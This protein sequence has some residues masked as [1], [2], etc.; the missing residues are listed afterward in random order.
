MGN[1]KTAVILAVCLCLF[2]GVIAWAE[3]DEKNKKESSGDILLAYIQ[4]S[5]GEG[6]SS[7]AVGGRL[8]L[9]VDNNVSSRLRASYGMATFNSDDA[10]GDVVSD[11]SFYEL[12]YIEYI[13]KKESGDATYWGFGVGNATSEDNRRSVVTGTVQTSSD[14]TLTLSVVYGMEKGMAYGELGYMHFTS[15]E[16]V[17]GLLIIGVGYKL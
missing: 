6:Y 14:S 4:P 13:E 5:G 9:Y 16:N 11:L 8:S 7:G 2:T 17:R 10:M 1:A 12:S 3:G 15:T